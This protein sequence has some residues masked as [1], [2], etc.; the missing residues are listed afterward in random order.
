MPEIAEVHLNT[1]LFLKPF[2][3][4]NPLLTNIAILPC[5]K[6]ARN[7]PNNFTEFKKL[8]PANIVFVGNR[9]KFTWFCLDNGWIVGFGLGMTGLLS[10][11]EMKHSRIKLTNGDNNNLY[12][13]DQRNFGNWFFW[14]DS[15]KLDQKLNTLGFDFLQQPN[16]PKIKII[17][18]FRAFEKHEI[19]KALMSQ[20][21]LAGVGNYLKAEALYEAKIYPFAK[22]SD[23]SDSDL[24]AIY[25]SL[26]KWAKLAY[27]AQQI[28]L[29]KG[30]SYKGFQSMMNIY[31]KSKC[32][33][34]KEIK[35]VKTR[36][37]R[38]THW[39]PEV[40]IIGKSD[41]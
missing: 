19:T 31:K 39:V 23:L 1:D 5:G 36:D 32:P 26:V 24:F 6:Y 15:E 10:E 16:L 12:Y 2:I 28:P 35:T 37:N 14:R 18:Q 27:K 33:L 11:E 41:E 38:I 20:K 22:V 30:G 13:V 4:N 17:N 29:E 9:G 3:Q 7:P 34:G 25:Q 8:L 21:I 40:Q